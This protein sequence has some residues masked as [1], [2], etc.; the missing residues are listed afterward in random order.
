MA[1]EIPPLNRTYIFKRTIVHCHVS[2]RSENQEKT[3]K[4]AWVKKEVIPNY[5]YETVKY[6]WSSFI[7]DIAAG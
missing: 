7:L 6:L 4:S 1:L 5:E 2:Y 3:L